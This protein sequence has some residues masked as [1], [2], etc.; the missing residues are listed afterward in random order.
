M[1]IVSHVENVENNEME[2]AS[3]LNKWLISGGEQKVFRLYFSWDT[4]NAV[5]T[6]LSLKHTKDGFYVTIYQVVLRSL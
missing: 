4:K 3:L 2:V 6:I 5:V 1:E